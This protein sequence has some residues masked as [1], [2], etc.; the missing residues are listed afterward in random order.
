MAVRSARHLTPTRHRQ[1]S[2][3]PKRKKFEKFH[4]SPQYE[5]R[6]VAR[7]F[8]RGLFASSVDSGGDTCI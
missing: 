8:S 3:S 7:F 1:L 2:K 6:R 5:R 4:F